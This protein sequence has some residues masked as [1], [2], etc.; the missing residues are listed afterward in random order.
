MSP[1]QA[2]G[3]DVDKRTDI[4]AFG[5]VLY[6]M[7]TGKS[8]FPGKN[9]KEILAAVI[10][11][12]PEW[13]SLPEDLNERLREVLER[14]LEKEPRNRCHDISDVRLDIQKA[15]A[16]PRGLLVKLPK[17]AEPRT[18][19]RTLLPWVAAII[20]PAIIA[21]LVLLYLRDPDPNRVVRLDHDL[22]EGQQFSDLAFP[23]L[24]VSPDG[25]QIVYSTSKAGL[26]CNR[27]SLESVRNYLRVI[28]PAI[29]RPDT[30]SMQ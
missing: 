17:T 28:V 18:G 9:L 22:L 26:W 5:C 10:R 1:E 7:L 12:E 19:L 13:R 11:S 15:L 2:Q 14:C 23:V 4:W 6:E 24:D 20:L 30:L 27:L 3:Q 25:R 16:D 8:A 21:G 29:Y